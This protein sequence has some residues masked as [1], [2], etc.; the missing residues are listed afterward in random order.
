MNQSLPRPVERVVAQLQQHGRK[1]EPR[2][3]SWTAQCPAHDD[4]RA[5]LSIREGRDGR[6]LLKCHAGCG[7]R[8]IAAAL[9]LEVRELFPTERPAPP[10]PVKAN[11]R[12]YGYRDA[13]GTLVYQVVRTPDK[14]FWTRRPE[15]KGGWVNNLEGVLP[16]PYR[17]PELRAL[18][19]DSLLF[20]GE[21]EKVVECLVAR[22][23]NATTN[24]GG[25]GKWHPAHSRHCRGLR[26][27]VLP[28]EDEAGRAHASAVLA[29]LREEG[30]EAA[31]LA[32][33]G[34]PPKGDAV[35]W[36]QAGGTAAALEALAHQALAAARDVP[37]DL[38]GEE[39]SAA[40]DEG[41]DEAAALSVPLPAPLAPE[42]FHGIA[43]E[44]VH[45]IEP[46][47]E[48][49]PAALLITF[50]TAIGN[51]I[52]PGPTPG[53]AP[54]I[55]R[56]SCSSSSS[57]PLPKAAKGRAKTTC[58]RCCRRW[59]RIGRRCASSPASAA[60]RASSTRCATRAKARSG[61]RRPRPGT[62]CCGTRA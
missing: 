3:D 19:P 58:A 37:S 20:I 2:G 11:R 28:D 5:S 39:H 60:A 41:T 24:H 6:A 33:P 4:Q 26:V 17:L 57:A 49:D 16:V 25:A 46:H 51:L 44:I 32:L 47:T 45:A 59:T 14:R 15:G 35:E 7:W 23:L 10:A 55:T 22:G 53:S 42:A 34:L 9:G 50:L 43:G 56:R 54:P 36:F 13:A 12:E 21:G 62:G 38:R 27:V 31:L 30:V 8:Q 29:S 18:A 1:V 48:A 52:G 40:H 61:T